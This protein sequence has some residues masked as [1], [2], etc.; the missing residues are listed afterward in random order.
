MSVVFV[1]FSVCVFRWTWCYN[2]YN[3][4]PYM[5]NTH[6]VIMLVDVSVKS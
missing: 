5:P 3:V 1:E 4:L 6:Y 2:A